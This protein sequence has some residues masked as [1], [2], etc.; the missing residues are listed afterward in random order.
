MD[1][2]GRLEGSYNNDTVIN[3]QKVGQQ[4]AIDHNPTMTVNLS[5]YSF[6]FHRK[7][8]WRDSITLS[9]SSVDI[10]MIY[11]VKE[12]NFSCTS[13]VNEL[14]DANVCGCVFLSCVPAS[15]K[16][17]KAFVTTTDS[18]EQNALQ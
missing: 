12:P 16:A 1:H 11:I 10:H 9:E 13:F 7:E 5:K 18:A 2:V 17:F 14:D 15:R 4:F 3:E 6:Q 8:H